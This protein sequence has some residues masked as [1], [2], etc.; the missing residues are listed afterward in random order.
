M[1]VGAQQIEAP[2]GL[3]NPIARLRQASPDPGSVDPSDR[4]L[5]LLA[6]CRLAGGTFPLV[7]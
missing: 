6:L 4:F 3:S 1:S 5:L 2:V 7:A